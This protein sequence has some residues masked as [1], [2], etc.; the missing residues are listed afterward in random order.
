MSTTP[1][2]ILPRRDP[3]PSTADGCSRWAGLGCAVTIIVLAV[4]VFGSFLFFDRGVRWAVR[5]AS[6]RIEERL[7]PGVPP[8]LRDRLHGELEALI[9]RSGERG[10]AARNGAF[11]ERAGRFLEDGRVSPEEAEELEAFLAGKEGAGERESGD[12]LP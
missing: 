5:R 9:A 10:A 12:G 2:I 1:P 6:D 8:A 11:L 7:D 3:A 4:L